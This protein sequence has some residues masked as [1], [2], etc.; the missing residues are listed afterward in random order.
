MN[1]QSSYR[2]KNHR[3]PYW[4]YSNSGIYFLTICVKNRACIFGEVINKKMVLNKFGEIAKNEWLSSAD[5]RDNFEL[6][7]F[8]IMPNHIHGI[9][10][11]D[12][13]CRAARPC[14]PTPCATN[15]QTQELI[16]MPFRKPKSISSFMAGYKSAVVSKI[17]DW[18]DQNDS[19]IKKYN[20]KNK[21]WQD[22]YHDHIIR[23]KDEFIRIKN[24]ILQN[25]AKW[26]DDKFY[27]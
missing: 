15:N 6:D 10:I 20:R 4:D 14:G 5:I 11:I 13:K 26:K 3:K 7:A 2:G 12:N 21:L 18:I 16:Q 25:P 9:V 17:D 23:N 24:Y 22:N 19:S 1:S 8:V 27:G